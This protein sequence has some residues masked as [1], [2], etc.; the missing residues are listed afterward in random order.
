MTSL[1]ASA[2][3]LDDATY[4]EPLFANLTRMS[5][6]LTLSG[7]GFHGA[8]DHYLALLAALQRGLIARAESLFE[9]AEQLESAMDHA[10]R[11]CKTWMAWA[12][13]IARRAPHDESER[14]RAL[15]QLDRAIVLA[16]ERELPR[17]Y[18]RACA[19]RA[20]LASRA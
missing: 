9:A 17:T 11:L 8:V 1:A 7:A 15:E 12:D 4:A 18:A 5:G 19:Q 20:A 3:F 10:P 16:A 2:W 13:T 14:Q 6:Q